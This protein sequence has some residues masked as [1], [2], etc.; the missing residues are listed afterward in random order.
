TH[1]FRTLEL[2]V[3]TTGAHPATRMIY[4]GAGMPRHPLSH[5]GR[6]YD[7]VFMGFEDPEPDVSALRR[8]SVIDTV[9][10]DLTSLR[11]RLGAADRARLEAHEAS[12]REIELSLGTTDPGTCT[13]HAPPMGSSLAVTIDQ[14]SQLLATAIAC[15]RTSIASMQVRIADNDA[16]LYPWVGI[17]TGGHHLTSHDQSTTAQGNLADLYR[18]Y[19]ERFAHLLD[20]LDA[21]PDG[22]GFSVLDNSFVVWGSEIGV[23]WNHDVS[24]VPFVVAGGAA[25]RMVG[26]RHLDLRGMNLQ[27]NRV[28]VDCFRAMGVGD[29]STW[30]ST[31]NG[32]GGVPGLLT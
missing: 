3:G 19:A 20:M 29:V 13:L 24:N 12:L 5:P 21:I 4:T 16:S 26:G 17:D 22:D 27:H 15:E 25:G 8:R 9:V 30:G 10:E 7:Q 31:D 11:G 23:G 1:P 2:G 32:S 14:Q 28:L 6:A 18:W